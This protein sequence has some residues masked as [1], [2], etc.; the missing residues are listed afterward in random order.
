M[1]LFV[2]AESVTE[3]EGKEM[4]IVVPLE[5]LAV[6]EDEE[7]GPYV[8]LV[9]PDALLLEEKPVVDETP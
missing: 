6:P 9:L 8:L 3:V 1:G 7:E 5:V 2:D 4:V